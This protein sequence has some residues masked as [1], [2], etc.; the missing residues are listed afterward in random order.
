MPSI[1][2]VN[3]ATIVLFSDSLTVV[4]ASKTFQVFSAYPYLAK[5]ILIRYTYPVLPSMKICSDT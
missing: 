3:G 4:L 2:L 5:P 1:L